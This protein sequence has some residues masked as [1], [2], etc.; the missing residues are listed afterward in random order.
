MS[1]KYTTL[2]ER[3]VANTV[4]A[5]ED[6]PNSCWVWTGPRRGRYGCLCVRVPGGGRSTKP[7][8]I[9]AHR[10]MLEEFHNIVFP[11]D[12]GGHTCYERLCINPMHLEVQTRV[13]NLG[14]RRG[15]S[16]VEGCMIPVLYPRDDDALIPF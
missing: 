16:M 10:A 9:S 4:L 8:T 13:H 5:E 15:Y 6:N 1:R 14:E 11:F 2:Y 3:L 12:E 7:K